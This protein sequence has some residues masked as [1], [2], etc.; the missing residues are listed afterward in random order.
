MGVLHGVIVLKKF[1]LT[2]VKNG[3]EEFMKD[4]GNGDYDYSNREERLDSCLNTA[5]AAGDL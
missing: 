5:N 2:C 4:Y 1:F 3:K